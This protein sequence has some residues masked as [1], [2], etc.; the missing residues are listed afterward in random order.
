MFVDDGLNG[1]IHIVSHLVKTR[2]DARDADHAVFVCFGTVFVLKF[3]SHRK[4]EVVQVRKR[5]CCVHGDGDND[6]QDVGEK[7]F[8]C[9]DFI[10]FI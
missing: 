4:T 10:A 1:H 2:Q 7:E 9:F 8:I 3:D 6:G 5:V